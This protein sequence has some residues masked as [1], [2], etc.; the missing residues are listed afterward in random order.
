LLEAVECL[1]ELAGLVG[2]AGAISRGL[3][4]KY[5]FINDAVEKSGLEVQL[6]HVQVLGGDDG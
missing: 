5:F 4:D 6:V 3:L 1:D 2:F